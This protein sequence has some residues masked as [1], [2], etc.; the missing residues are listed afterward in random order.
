MSPIASVLDCHISSSRSWELLRTGRWHD[1]TSFPPGNQRSNCQEILLDFEILLRG[2]IGYT[3]QPSKVNEQHKTKS[4]CDTESQH[5]EL[6]CFDPQNWIKSWTIYRNHY[7]SLS[8]SDS[9]V[10]H[11]CGNTFW[12]GCFGYQHHVIIIQLTLQSENQKFKT[13]NETLIQC[14]WYSKKPTVEN[15]VVHQLPGTVAVYKS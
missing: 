2:W 5:D 3:K 13:K 10:V 4:R 12:S 6:H 11:L 9:W 7:C 8:T 15:Y 14:P 1:R